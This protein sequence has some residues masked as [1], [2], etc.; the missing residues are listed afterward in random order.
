VPNCTRVAAAIPALAASLGVLF[1]LALASAPLHTPATALLF[2]LVLGCMAGLVPIAATNSSFAWNRRHAWQR[3]GSVVAIC[4]ML[5]VTG[6]TG[7]RAF[8]LLTENRQA[9]AAATMAATGQPRG[10]ERLYGSALTRAPWDHE[11]GVALASLLIYQ[12]RPDAALRVL[13]RIDAWS[14]SREGWLARTRA[15]M[16]K[17]DTRTALRVTEYATAAVPDFLRAQMLR[18][19]LAARLGKTSEARAA[20]RQMLLSPQRSARAQRITFEAAQA[21]KAQAQAP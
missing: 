21:L 5:A 14:Q 7:H 20:W 16:L 2:W 6:W 1:M 3:A 9:A 13:D 12:Y 17:N 18:A 11:S 19:R 8:V 10:A 15:W 4:A